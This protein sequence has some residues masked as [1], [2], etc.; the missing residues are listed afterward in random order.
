MLERQLNPGV[1][2]WTTRDG[3]GSAAELRTLNSSQPNTPARIASPAPST[4]ASVKNKEEVNLA[5]FRQPNL[6]KS[7]IYHTLLHASRDAEAHWEGVD[8]RRML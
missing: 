6:V 1:G 5:N 4:A 8:V 7:T 2:C 3:N